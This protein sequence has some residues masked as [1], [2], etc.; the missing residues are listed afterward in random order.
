M[1]SPLES[2]RFALE[3]LRRNLTRSLLT[4]LGV[5]IGVASVVVLVAVGR[6]ARE[7]ISQKIASVGSNLIMVVPGVSQKDGVFMG[8]GTVHSLTAADAEAIERE[9]PSVKR[10]ASI[11]GQSAQ[12]ISGNKN[13]R[14]RVSGVSTAYFDL[15]EWKIRHGR[16]FSLSEEK[17][18]SKVC[19]LGSRALEALMPNSYPIDMIVRIQSVPFRVIGSLESKGQSYSGEDQDDVILVPLK[20]AHLRLFGTP[21][22][23]EVRLILVQ[24]RG[25]SSVSQ[26]LTEVD[27]L[28]IRRHRVGLNRDK[29]FTVRSLTE[30][31]QAAQRSVEIMSVF[32]G[33][34]AAISLFVGGIGIMNIMLVSV[35]E[36][37][38]EIGVRMAVGA[39]PIDIL[40]QF[41]IEAVSLSVAGGIFGIMLGMA[42]AY[43]VAH[44]SGWPAIIGP[45]ELAAAVVVSVSAGI[46][47]GFFPAV[48]ASRLHPIDA[49]RFE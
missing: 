2:L 19:V 29:D 4:V 44:A 28:L 6:G 45:L 46:I 31:Q 25:T 14:T 20:T 49:L 18:A 8:S 42:G 34:I 1:I 22:L 17:N 23:G 11:Y 30:S 43:V 5:V 24:A 12:V 10:V 37:T 3:S 36:R 26:A 48:K 7:E 41:L 38:R 40:I 32:L 15:R 21:F 33:S 16:T 27:D 39:K 9:C 35:T 47:S 13:W